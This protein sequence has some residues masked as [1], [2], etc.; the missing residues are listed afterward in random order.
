MQTYVHLTLF[1]TSQVAI[2][3][4]THRAL[5]QELP[6]ACAVRSS[7]S[8][9]VDAAAFV[10]LDGV[11][12]GDATPPPSPA[13]EAFPLST[14]PLPPPYPLPTID[15]FLPYVDPSRRAA[16]ATLQ[17]SACLSSLCAIHISA[18]SHRR[19]LTRTMGYPLYVTL[20]PHTQNDSET[21]IRHLAKLLANGTLNALV[22]LDLISSHTRMTIVSRLNATEDESGGGVASSPYPVPDLTLLASA[23][24]SPYHV[25]PRGPRGS[26]YFVL[27][28]GVAFGLATGCVVL[29]TTIGRGSA[30]K[31]E[32][33]LLLQ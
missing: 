8:S 18:T 1:T 23:Y 7:R 11:C 19:G 31:A 24:A 32:Q 6:G 14:P 26:V 27:M 9:F 20:L 21:V 3:C 4:R 28:F 15:T 25:A 29:A 10:E 12:D 22:S 2:T 33:P 13:D 30:V 17:P 16:D 5:I